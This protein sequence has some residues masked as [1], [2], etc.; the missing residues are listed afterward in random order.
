MVLS[1][2]LIVYRRI[3]KV[4]DRGLDSRSGETSYRQ[5]SWSLEA[6][7]LDVIMIVSF[8]NL[9]SISAA[10]LPRGACQISERLEKPKHESRWPCIPQL[11]KHKHIDE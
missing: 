8:L 6:T 3:H 5:I 4:I 11:S 9:T 7:R 1:F 10:L 2:R